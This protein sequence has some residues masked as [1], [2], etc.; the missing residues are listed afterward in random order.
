MP[1]RVATCRA[2]LVG[3]LAALI[4]CAAPLS[5]APAQSAALKKIDSQLLYEIRQ[6]SPARNQQNRPP[7]QETVVR[8]DAKQRAFVDVR[9]D[10]TPALEE[11]IRQ[12]GGTIHSTSTPH[13]SIIGWIPL[14]ELE[15]L[16]A[17]AAVHSIMPAAEAAIRQP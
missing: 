1:A 16:A 5:E 15:R 10:V 12:L 11:Q 6:L 13:R 8:L 7:R 2:I 17:S 4:G 9:A 14:R 3:G